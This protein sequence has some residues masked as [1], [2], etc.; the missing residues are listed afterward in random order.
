MFGCF[1][2]GTT[3]VYVKRED[4]FTTIDRQRGRNKADDS[5][6]GKD[7]LVR[8]TGSTMG[9]S[10]QIECVSTAASMS[11]SMSEIVTIVGNALLPTGRTMNKWAA[12][13]KTRMAPHPILSITLARS[14]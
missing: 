14:V 12:F 2:V 5:E 4:L 8:V 11:K 9:Q 10:T 1:S 13:N 7:S 3:H 6:S